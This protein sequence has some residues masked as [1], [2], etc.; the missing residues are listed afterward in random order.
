MSSKKKSKKS[1]NKFDKN[2]YRK[3]AEN[4]DNSIIDMT[5]AWSLN[6][7]SD[8]AKNLF[9]QLTG[10]VKPTEVTNSVIRKLAILS[11]TDVGMNDRDPYGNGD[12]S[13]VGANTIEGEPTRQILRELFSEGGDLMSY[14]IFKGFSHFALSCGLGNGKAV[15]RAIKATK[16]GSEERMKL[17]EKR[18]TSMRFSPLLL[19][20]AT[21]KVK[22]TVRLKMMTGAREADMDHLGVIKI[23]LR[24]G[25]KPDIRDLT[26]KS[27]V[28]YAAGVMALPDTLEMTDYFVDAAK[29]SAHFGKK[30]IL[31]NLSKIDYNG[32]TGTLGG[33]I[34]ETGRRQV[35]IDSGKRNLALNPKNIFEVGSGNET[36]I[37]DSSRNIVNEPDRLGS[38]SLHEVFL[39]QRVDV[40]KFLI[41]HNVSIDIME[42]GQCSVRSMAFR[43]SVTGISEM[44]HTIRK[45]AIK[46][47][48]VE[49]NR[50]LQCQE[51]VKSVSQ[52][53][54]CR[55]A[56][57]CSKECQKKHWPEHK[58]GCKSPDEYSIKLIKPPDDLLNVLKAMTNRDGIENN[59]K[60]Q[61]PKGIKANELFWIKVQCNSDIAPHLVYDKTRFC[62][63]LVAPN[64][65]GYHEL[66][67]KVSKEKACFGRKAFFKAA[68][69]ASGNCRFYPNTIAVK[70]W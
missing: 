60:Y 5:A 25:A 9:K 61:K 2:A 19:T 32:L 42:G 1:K 20:V 27:V 15:E 52:C 57:Y 28:H 26:G 40:A 43:A 56:L 31:R 11:G 65:P 22:P 34:T 53:S 70:S 55:W 12:Q 45:Y 44:S 33:Y 46:I 21:S 58:L 7:K 64:T 8:E 69:D 4:G 39:S 14:F 66:Y 62:N 48:K 67:E 36:C 18:E 47:K 29:T 41:K 17:L 68:F 51:I 30:V 6:C 35:I 63:F 3:A 38:T 49:N 59:G 24:Y 54:R 10:G 16:V 50:C 37:F 13:N 23:L